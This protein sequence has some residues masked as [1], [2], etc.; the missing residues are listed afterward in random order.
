MNKIAKNLIKNTW[1]SITSS[2]PDPI[3][4]LTVAFN[5]NTNP[6]KVNLGVGAYRNNEGKSFMLESVKAA[7]ARQLGKPIDYAPIDGLPEF[8]KAAQTLAF[9]DLAEQLPI[10]TVQTLSGTGS[11]RVGAEFIR[12]WM[13]IAN[14]IAYARLHGNPY[15]VKIPEPTW[16]THSKIL[17]K[18][19]IESNVYSYYDRTRNQL[20]F[21]KMCRDILQMN[22]GSVV[23]FHACAHNP[24]GTDPTLEQWKE[25]SHICKT[26]NHIVW[27]DSAYQGFAS[28][29][30]SADSESYKIFIRDGHP[31]ILSQSFAK[32]MGL[33]GMRVGALHVVTGNSD[34]KTNVTDKLK[35]IIR[36]M[37]S[38]PPV[39]G[40]RVVAEI[41]SDP[42]L[43]KLWAS[44]L[45]LMAGR[46][47]EMRLEL[48][49]KLEAAGSTQDWSHITRQIGMFA[50]TG[51]NSNHVNTLINKHHIFLTSDGRISIPGLNS[52]NIDYVAK[53]IHSVTNN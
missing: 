31:I 19:G 36:P 42:L 52:G 6:N 48:K 4:G 20:D 18:A 8:I 13:G 27:F 38:S 2:Y 53:C 44:E 14:P 41:V 51:L 35:T 3:L 32:N 26:R 16:P 1:G 47:K 43:S 50:Y 33:Y 24:T 45:K 23:L 5:A 39:E 49:T 9:G 28:G 22:P 11:L 12:E 25:L 34:E 29:D 30:L 15:I 21:G 10:A 40:A 37:Y 46:I 17:D 7:Q